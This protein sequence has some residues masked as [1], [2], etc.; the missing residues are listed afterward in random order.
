MWYPAYK[1]EVDRPIDRPYRVA[2]EIGTV[3]K[4]THLYHFH[5]AT[6]NPVDGGLV[7]AAAAANGVASLAFPLNGIRGETRGNAA[8]E[9]RAG[10]HT[11][12]R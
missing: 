9:N 1:M 4:L 7:L 10:G 2:R 11:Q 12:R 3:R 6:R 5:S 8:R